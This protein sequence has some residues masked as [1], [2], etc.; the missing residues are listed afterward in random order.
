MSDRRSPG[1]KVR[2]RWSLLRVSQP[3]AGPVRLCQPHVLLCR[4]KRLDHMPFRCLGPSRSLHDSVP[5]LM[6]CTGVFTDAAVEGVFAD[7]LQFYFLGDE[8]KQLNSDSR[9]TF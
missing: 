6:V 7:E 8:V 3:L 2:E 5:L 1:Y 4:R 9:R